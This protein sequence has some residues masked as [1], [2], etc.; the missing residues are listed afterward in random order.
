MKINF[1]SNTVYGCRM[2]SPDS[3]GQTQGFCEPINGRAFLPNTD[4]YFS[5]PC[6]CPR[7]E[8]I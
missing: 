6:P 8:D 3:E 5:G 1:Q 7:N 4:K 2:D